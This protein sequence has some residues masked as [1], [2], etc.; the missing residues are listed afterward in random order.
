M[1]LMQQVRVLQ[2][3][4]VNGVAGVVRLNF[5]SQILSVCLHFACNVCT[6]IT[7][8][9]VE[10][11]ILFHKF[12]ITKSRKKLKKKHNKCN[13]SYECKLLRFFYTK[14]M[15]GTSFLVHTFI[16]TYFNYQ[17]FTFLLFFPLF[18]CAKQTYTIPEV[19]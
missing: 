7:D 3:A 15:R 13:Y 9:I 12:Q 19:V 18:T 11:Y 16:R 1:S 5:R 4:Q 8:Y 2:G 10:S 17:R 14:P 6:L